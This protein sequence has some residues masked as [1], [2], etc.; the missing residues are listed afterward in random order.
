M[1]VA[2]SLFICFHLPH[3]PSFFPSSVDS[4]FPDGNPDSLSPSSSFGAFSS[5][6]QESSTSSAKS[7]VD[8]PVPGQDPVI[9]LDEALPQGSVEDDESGEGED[10][11]GDSPPS[12]PP[13][14]PSSPSRTA[15]ITEEEAL[16]EEMA[17]YS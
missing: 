14:K 15:S 6:Q 11:K 8:P 17:S 12:P 13:P 5:N 7:P 2:I 3:L 9:V 1:L 16:G 10:E 4:P